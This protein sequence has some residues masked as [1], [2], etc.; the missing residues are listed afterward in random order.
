MDLKKVKR[1]TLEEVAAKVGLDP[2]KAPNKK[3]LIAWLEE[4]VEDLATMVEATMNARRD[5]PQM[6]AESQGKKFAGKHPITGEKV[7]V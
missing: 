3:V 5:L 1:E 7:F 6:A 2:A 4:A